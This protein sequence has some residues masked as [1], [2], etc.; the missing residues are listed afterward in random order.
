MP[1]VIGKGFGF[2]KGGYKVVGRPG[3][4]ACPG[5][6]DNDGTKKS[7]TQSGEQ[8]PDG[9]LRKRPAGTRRTVGDD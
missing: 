1:K 6:N 8:P 4:G 3:S 7:A 9:G 5:D 2:L